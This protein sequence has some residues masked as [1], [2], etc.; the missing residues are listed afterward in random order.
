MLIGSDNFLDGLLPNISLDGPGGEHM[1]FPEDIFYFL[2]CSP[3]GLG[4]AAENVDASGEV[5]GSED[6]IC[7]ETVRI[8]FKIM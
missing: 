2:E 6:K 1:T 3:S 7:L 4:E 8:S 5:E